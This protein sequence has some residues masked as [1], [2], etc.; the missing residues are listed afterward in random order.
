LAPAVQ[1]AIRSWRNVW[2]RVLLHVE[3]WG[4]SVAANDEVSWIPRIVIEM[5]S[6]SYHNL[7]S[8]RASVSER[9][10]SPAGSGGGQ[11]PAFRGGPGRGRR[12]SSVPVLCDHRLAIPSFLHSFHALRKNPLVLPADAVNSNFPPVLQ[13]S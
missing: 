3:T 6:S 12:A 8:S 7:I 5:H 2:F 4:E 13:F 1:T 10:R 11:S 9:R